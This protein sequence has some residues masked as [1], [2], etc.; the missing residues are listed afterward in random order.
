VKDRPE[1]ET[2]S[3]NNVRVANLKHT[4]SNQS[5]ADFYA[6]MDSRHLST[7]LKEQS[8]YVSGA[9]DGNIDEWP[10]YFKSSSQS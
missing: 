7:R 3:V 9:E 5:N 6:H 4:L 8:V 1:F 10:T 2:G